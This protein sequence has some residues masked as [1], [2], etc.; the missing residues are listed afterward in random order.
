MT[1]RQKR[2]QSLRL[3]L[4]LVCAIVF[5]AVISFF[6]V[7][8]RKNEHPYSI[9]LMTSL[10]WDE[11]KESSVYA[12]L[13]PGSEKEEILFTPGVTRTSPIEKQNSQSY[14]NFYND[15]LTNRGFFPITK[16]GSPENDKYWVAS[17]Q[18]G[19][20]YIEI[21]YYPT[22]YAEN[23]YTASVFSGILK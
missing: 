1:K 6:F 16:T 5:L 12:L 19:V 2:K 3:P 9:P 21:Q 8:S 11:P 22:P 4:F 14:F 18:K 13:Y 10:S 23:S 7:K 20:F 17:Y 15:E